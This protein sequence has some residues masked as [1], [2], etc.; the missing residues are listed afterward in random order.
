MKT[1]IKRCLLIIMILG[2]MGCGQQG[3]KPGGKSLSEVLMEVGRSTENAFYAFIEL[4]SDVLGFT[5]KASTTKQQVGDYFNRLGDKLGTA[6]GELEEVAVKSEKGVD[7]NDVSKNLIRDAVDVAKTTLNTLKDHLESLGTVGDAKPVGDAGSDATGAATN[8]GELKKALKA[9]KG[10]V[11]IAKGAGV[12]EPT[13]GTVAL[14]GTGV[15]NK[16]GARILATDNKA[17][18]ATDAGKASLILSAVSGEEIL[19]SIIKSEEGDSALGGSAPNENTTAVSFAKG[20]NVA[21]LANAS[22]PKAAAVA[23]G[24]A[25][26]SLVKD[27]KLASGAADNNAGGKQDVQGVGV[28]SINKLLRAVE[29]IINKTV[30]HVLGTAK[31]KIDEA[32]G[33]QVSSLESSK[34]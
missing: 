4:V 33:P 5:A 8:E 6:S 23:G 26:R 18:S 1:I 17:A 30:K 3:E 31:Q 12:A 28:T 34:K 20:G 15:D 9:L 13:V 25:L 7:K 11:E 22:T 29:D 2:V 10:I 16:E 27:G 19:A 24:I 21:N 32:R 14:N